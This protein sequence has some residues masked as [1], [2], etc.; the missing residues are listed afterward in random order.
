MISNRCV[1]LILNINQLTSDKII[2][3]QMQQFQFVFTDKRN[4]SPQFSAFNSLII[5]LARHLI[6]NLI[7]H[8]RCDMST[9][10]TANLQVVF[11]Y[12]SLI[13]FSFMLV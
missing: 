2:A 9:S 7:V 13:I 4:H 8:M 1:Q 11:C 12:K 3:R 10:K 6:L 5:Y